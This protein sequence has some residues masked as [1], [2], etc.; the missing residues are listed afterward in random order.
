MTTVKFASISCTLVLALATAARLLYGEAA[1][2]Q[3]GAT[4]VWQDRVGQPGGDDFSGV[5]ALAASNHA[6]FVPGTLANAN[7]DSD[8]LVRAYRG[9]DGSLLWQ[10]RFDTP[11]S[12]DGAI[13]IATAG[14]R[15]F[16]MGGTNFGFGF[17][18][19]RAYDDKTGLLLWHNQ[20]NDTR[21]VFDSAVIDKNRVIAVGGNRTWMVDAY[22]AETGEL[23]W[24]D[25][26]GAASGNRA[27]G[28]VESGGRVFVGGRARP[29]GATLNWL[30]RAYDS[31]TGDVLWE[32]HTPAGDFAQ[33]TQLAVEGNRVIAVGYVETNSSTAPFSETDW[34]VRT[35]DAKT[36]QIVWE[37]R[38]ETGGLD[39]IA[40]PFDVALLDGRAFVIGTGG[41]GCSFSVVGAPDNCDF[42]VRTY[43]IE[44]GQLL[45]E[46]RL[47]RAPIDQGLSIVAKGDAVFATGNGGNTC[48]GVALTNCD[49]FVRAYD[50]NTGTLL[51]E[52][53]V[54][55][56][57]TDDLGG[58]IATQGG[59]VFVAGVVI[60]A[61]FT[62]DILIRAYHLRD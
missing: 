4:L 25:R 18:V 37:E 6:I 39:S 56:M 14:G 59:S 22:E 61:D 19:I 58:A 55:T 8:F 41:P 46:D 7:G 20:V 35:Y 28:V 50:P 34:L 36:G 33:A 49:I 5:D 38:L 53:Q 10:D 43:N 24:R 26:F 21:G 42:I 57:G 60:D 31:R 52:D 62:A 23:L 2:A 47:D 29:A 48:A 17:P 44:T 30:V 3:A 27:I 16:A 45:W 40:I 13:G 1:L 51:W 32:D 11:G 12:F 54:D 9:N 15:V